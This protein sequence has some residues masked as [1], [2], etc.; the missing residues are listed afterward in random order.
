MREHTLP[1]A[2]AKAGAVSAL[3][4][5]LLALSG[6]GGAPAD[7]IVACEPRGG[8]TPYCGFV[9]PEDLAYFA[10]TGEIIVSQFASM[11]GSTPGNLASFHPEAPEP[12]ILY[13]NGERD[14]PES[15]WGDANCPG[16][17]GDRLAPHGIDL[18]ARPDGRHALLVVNHGGRESVEYFE[19]LDSDSHQLDVR[20]RGCVDMPDGSYLNDLVGLADGGF[21]ATHMFP[22]DAE[23]SSLL[24]GM[25]G[26]STGWVIEWRPGQGFAEIPGSRAAM[27]NG[28]ER[29]PNERYLYLNAYL[30]NEVRRIDVATGEL[31]ASADVPGPDNATW[32]ADGRLLVA[33]HHGG[34][35]QTLACQNLE[36]GTCALP[37]SIQALDPE[38]L[39]ATVL[40][41]GDA[42]PTGAVSVALEVQGELWLG[43][44]AGDRVARFP[45]PHRGLTGDPTAFD[46]RH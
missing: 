13:P 38:D 29:S 45:M 16:P 5:S 36:A 19:V 40:L 8:V 25:L 32:S 31:L 11:D 24:K 46:Q 42:L 35:R 3:L 39:T 2:A 18:I 30:G 23:L 17:P 28:I 37:F 20:W 44:F 33:S 14:Q 22:S 10:P 1:S 34:I 27:P 21:W 15:G 12:R 4:L 41:E 9:N 26:R 43:T 7:P 6:C